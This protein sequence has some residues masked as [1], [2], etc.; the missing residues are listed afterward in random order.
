VIS[1]LSDNHISKALNLSL[2]TTIKQ[3]DFIDKERWK[4]KE[5]IKLATALSFT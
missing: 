5:F 2:K 3:T 4:R 1:H